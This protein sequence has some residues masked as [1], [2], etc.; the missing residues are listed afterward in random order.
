MKKIKLLITSLPI[1]SL[2]VSGA[3]AIVLGLSA[4]QPVAAQLDGGIAGGAN[5]AKGDDQ[6]ESLDG[7]EGMFKK[8]TDVMLFIVGAVSVIMLIIGGIRYVVSGGDQG[9]VQ[10][11]KNT[12][13]YAVVGIIVTL[14]AYAV[15]NFVVTQFSAR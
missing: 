10:S 1:A 5:A 7:D 14:L 9:A 2:A 6:P 11:A 4:V 8:I 15:V 12:I 3:L 13:L